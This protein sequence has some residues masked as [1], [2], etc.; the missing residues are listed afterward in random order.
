MY[1]VKNLIINIFHFIYVHF[2]D[3]CIFHSK[4]V[5][6]LAYCSGEKKKCILEINS[7]IFIFLNS[8]RKVNSQSHFFLVLQNNFNLAIQL[9]SWFS[10]FSILFTFIL[11]S[12]IIFYSKTIHFLPYSSIFWRDKKKHSGNKIWNICFLKFNKKS[13]FSESL[14][15]QYFKRI[16]IWLFS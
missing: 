1:S 13:K 4:T 6:F 5:W 14:L 16:L 9:N 10:T 12:V 11:L 15:F 2:I 3:T 8:I 7:K